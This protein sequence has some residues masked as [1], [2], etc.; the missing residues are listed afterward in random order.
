MMNKRSNVQLE[1]NNSSFIVHHSSLFTRTFRVICN[2]KALGFA[3]IAV[4][5][6][7]ATANG[8]I[9]FDTRPTIVCCFLTIFSTGCCANKKA[10]SD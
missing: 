6:I 10:Q 3:T 7:V 8:F 1:A 2:A 5:F 4:R 9:N